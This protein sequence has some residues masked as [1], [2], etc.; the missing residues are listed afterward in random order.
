MSNATPLMFWTRMART[1]KRTTRFKNT[2]TFSFTFLAKINRSGRKIS[3]EPLL[4]TA[5]I[6]KRFQKFNMLRE[7]AKT[8]LT[9]C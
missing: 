6:K 8:T 5:I 9:S 3:V 7:T 2:Y 1:N 4:S